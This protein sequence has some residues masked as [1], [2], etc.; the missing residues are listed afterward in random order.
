[1]SNA[2]ITKQGS[3]VDHLGVWATNSAN[4][5]RGGYRPLCGNER[6]G[7]QSWKLVDWVELQT[8]NRPRKR[9]CQNCLTE[10]AEL[11]ELANR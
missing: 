10:L 1:M 11:T 5:Q 3:E 4:W 2:I 9:T 8:P 6:G 7:L